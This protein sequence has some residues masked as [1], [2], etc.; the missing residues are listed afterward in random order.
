MLGM[1]I[2]NMKRIMCRAAYSNSARRQI[3]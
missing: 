3:T 2:K 1:T